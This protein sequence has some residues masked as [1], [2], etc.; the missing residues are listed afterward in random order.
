MHFQKKL[1]QP[2][3]ASEPK[4][5]G[6]SGKRAH[7]SCPPWEGLGAQGIY[8]LSMVSI[9]HK[10]ILARFVGSV[11]KF[12]ILLVTIT[13][14][15]WCGTCLDWKIWQISALR[16]A[17]SNKVDQFFGQRLVFFMFHFRVYAAS[18][19]FLHNSMKCIRRVTLLS[20]LGGTKKYCR[21][22]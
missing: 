22:M 7:H 8:L 18:M 20:H 4:T 15:K 5:L 14:I 2:K 11:N 17:Y 10:L 19:P 1:F 3:F 6:Y 21:F 12:S 13:V 9:W 16:P